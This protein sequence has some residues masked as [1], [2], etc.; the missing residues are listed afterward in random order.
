MCSLVYQAILP[1]M[2]VHIQQHFVSLVVNGNVATTGCSA[3]YISTFSNLTTTHCYL[4]KKK[5]KQQ[6]PLSANSLSLSLSLTLTLDQEIIIQ[7]QK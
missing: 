4:L 5:K 7:L 6:L 3:G 1:R 2:Y